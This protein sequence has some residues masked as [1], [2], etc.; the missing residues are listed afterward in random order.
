MVIVIQEFM[1]LFLIHNFHVNCFSLPGTTTA[2]STQLRPPE[3][4]AE[5]CWG[6][7]SKTGHVMNST[8]LIDFPLFEGLEGHTSSGSAGWVVVDLNCESQRFEAPSYNT[9]R[10]PTE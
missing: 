9:V 2:D 10:F 1:Y 6:P 7:T 8:Q 4:S 5:E 3:T